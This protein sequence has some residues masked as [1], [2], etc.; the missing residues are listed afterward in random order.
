[1]EKER[2]KPSLGAVT[3]PTVFAPTLADQSDLPITIMNLSRKESDALM[4]HCRLGHVILKCIIK[5]CSS[6][7]LPCLPSKLTNKDFICEDCLASKSKRHRGTRVSDRGELK[8]MNM[9]VLDLLG[10]FVDGFLGVQYILVFRDLTTTYSKGFL[11]KSKRDVCLTF[12]QYIERMEGLTGRQLKTFR[13]D[14]GS[15]FTSKAFL[16]WMK[17][18][19]IT[20]QHS[21]P[22]EPEENGAAERLH[23]TVG[24]MVRRLVASGLPVKF[25]GFAYLWGY[26]THNRLVNTLTGYKTPLELM[27]NKK[28][29]YDRL[30][31]FGEVAFVHKLELYRKGKTDTRAWR[32]NVVGY[33]QG[34]K[35][36]IF[37]VPTNKTFFESSIATF[38]YSNQLIINTPAPVQPK[39]SMSSSINKLLI[40]G[41]IATTIPNHDFNEPMNTIESQ[42]PTD[43]GF[44]DVA[45]NQLMPLVGCVQHRIK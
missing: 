12:K 20:H 18:K 34:G 41:P 27:F 5:M 23:C 44:A 38:P 24:K 14:G 4:W 11:L 45:R 3:I 42:K 13:T 40:N 31:S 15:K 32:C 10:P 8:P 43:T 6:G 2:K 22:Y 19:G 33:F 37:Y 21:M 1:M 16:D 28:P 26:F 36:W 17:D 25:W 30:C 7:E 39:I 35:G 29:I 9:I